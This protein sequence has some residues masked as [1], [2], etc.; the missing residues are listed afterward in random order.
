M[1]NGDKKNKLDLPVKISKT[2]SWILRH[3]LIELGLVSD[4]LGRIPLNTLLKLDQ[5][6]QIGATRELVLDVIKSNDK[7]RFRLDIVNGQEMIGANQGHSKEIG[8]TIDNK[9]L[10]V[11]ITKPIDLCVHGTYSNV[12]KEIKKYGLKT[13][14]RTHIHFAS[15]YPDNNIVISG[16]RPNANVFIEIDMEKTMCDNIDFYISSNGVILSGGVNGVIE[17]KYFKNIIYK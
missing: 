8:D 11:K 15:G 2:M 9:K 12:I 1:N 6:K 3:G 7:Q 17:P 4:K 16:A 5:M 10:M 14:N 13:M